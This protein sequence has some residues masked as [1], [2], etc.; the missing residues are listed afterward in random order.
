M[1]GM[2][3]LEEVAVP[4][5]IR[6]ALLA[7][8]MV[9]VVVLAILAALGLLTRGG[10]A[11]NP[12]LLT[13]ALVAPQA[14]MLAAVWLFGIRRCRA[15]WRSIG[16][17]RP[18][19]R[20]AML[21]S[22][23]VA[24]ASIAAAAI[25]ALAVSALGLDALA[26]PEIPQDLLGDGLLRLANAAVIG[27][28]GPLVEEVFFRGFLLAALAQPLGVFRAAI[29]ASAVFSAA[30]VSVGVMIPLFATGLLLSWLYLKTR[31]IWPPFAA[32]AAQNLITLAAIASAEG[33]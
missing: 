9:A 4:W 19:Q 12:V 10:E 24:L 28:A 29:V 17:A 31:S 18:A 11:V 20:W 26:P 23:P 27:L 2:M 16:F 13:A 21:M 5:G 3:S 25:Y 30:H 1:T 32:H 8:G 7:M 33:M 15:G 6:D 22:W 14:A